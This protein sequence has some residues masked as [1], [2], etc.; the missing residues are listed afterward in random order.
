ML[1]EDVQD[2]RRAVDDLDLDDV[3]QSAPLRRCQFGIHHHGVRAGGHH[4]VLEFQGLAGAEERAGV[5]LRPALDQPVEDF[6][7]RGFRQGG[8]FTQGVLGVGE[9][10]FGPQPG[11]DHALQAQLPVLD[12]GDVFEFGG[13]ARR[14]AQGPAFLEILLV[15]VERAVF[16]VKPGDGLGLAKHRLA[17]GSVPSAAAAFLAGTSLERIRSM[18]AWI[19]SGLMSW[20]AGSDPVL[21]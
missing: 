2:Q 10:A 19:S 4:D 8:E 11:Q 13:Q 15:A 17:A 18:T 16:L 12:F 5:R 1:G 20:A 3:F 6:R 14:A 7:A 21:C 9:G